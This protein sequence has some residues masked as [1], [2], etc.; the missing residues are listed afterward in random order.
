MAVTQ[1]IGSRYVP[2]FADPL[3]W[4][5]TKQ[6]EPL[7]I[8]YYQGN[9]FTS[10]QSVPT[11]IDITNTDYWAIT[12]NYNAQIE[13][14]RREVAAFD[15]RITANAQAI[16]DEVTARMA[17]DT[18]IRR[19]IDDLQ[20]SLD[21]EIAARTAA[22]T[23]IRTDFTA[24][25]TQIQT[26]FAAADTQIRTD[27]T[28]ADT[29]LSNRI[30][31]TEHMGRVCILI[32]DSYGEGYTPDGSV[33][34][35][36][37]RAAGYLAKAGIVAKYK[38]RGG[39]RIADGSFLTDLQSVVNQMTN[40]EKVRCDKVIICGGFNDRNS[41]EAD[42]NTGMVNIANYIR[43]NL[44][45][46]KCI[47]SFVGK[48]IT[49]RT[50]G[51]HATATMQSVYNACSSWRQGCGIAGLGFDEGAIGT[52][53]DDNMFS[54]DFV[55][56]NASGLTAIAA[57]I[58]TLVVGGAVNRWLDVTIPADAWSNGNATIEVKKQVLG[59]LDYSGL[60]TQALFGTTDDPVMVF[61][62]PATDYTCNGTILRNLAYLRS[63]TTTGLTLIFPCS[64]IFHNT[65]GGFYGTSGRFIIGHDGS[66]GVS[67][68]NV[69]G[70]NYTTIN[71]NK[72]QVILTSHLSYL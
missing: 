46:A 43:D 52:L 45:N 8:V 25:D 62:F 72:V 56:P 32:G 21:D 66:V 22:D 23:Q 19:I 26:D 2:L 3:D 54:S 30:T 59:R 41:S 58:A 69:T 31:Q 55:H 35:W 18:A 34:G 57:R 71:T 49:G 17:E 63:A 20:D 68:F 1:Y 10:K 39:T 5:I 60:L 24:A 16:A 13:N 67:A 51:S 44:P 28:A 27:F 37:V 50:T 14:Y 4:D 70:S 12:G 9:S 15:G 64:L 53:W 48:C 7:T 47:L 61:S 6:Y 65:G 33:D 38:Y 36:C 42:I 11:N 40:A 29:A